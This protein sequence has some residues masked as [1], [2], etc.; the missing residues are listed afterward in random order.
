MIILSEKQEN[1]SDLSFRVVKNILS[2]IEKYVSVEKCM[3][4]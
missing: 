1:E 3:Q 2:K 4:S